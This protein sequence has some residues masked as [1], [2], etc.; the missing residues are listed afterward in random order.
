MQPEN[1][2]RIPVNLTGNQID[3]SRKMLTGYRPVRAGTMHIQIIPPLR[4]DQDTVITGNMV[5]SG[6][7]FPVQEF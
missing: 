2:E 6:G 3:H 4:K 7:Q 5:K 1:H